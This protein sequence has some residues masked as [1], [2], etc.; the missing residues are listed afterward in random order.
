MIYYRRVP[1]LDQKKQDLKETK[2]S[3]FP[4]TDQKDRFVKK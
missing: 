1:F 4:S 2:A 3:R